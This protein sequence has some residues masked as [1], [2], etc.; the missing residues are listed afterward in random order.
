MFALISRAEKLATLTDFMKP[1]Y[2]AV[3]EVQFYVIEKAQ[4]YVYSLK[5][6]SLKKKFGKAGEGPQEFKIGGDPD[7]L[8]LFPQ[9][10][11]LFF[12]SL[13]KISFFTKGGKFIKE[14]R[15]TS[16]IP[17][18]QPMGSQFVGA[19]M[20]F[21]ED[22][23]LSFAVNLYN[24]NLEKVR[25][26]HRQKMVSRGRLQFPIIRPSFSVSDNKIILRGEGGFLVNIFDKNG[27]IFHKKGI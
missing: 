2:L 7:D 1:T 27:N 6:F 8:I 20:L 3:D 26:I 18:F 11:Y 14:K 16:Q 4:V 19:A 9:P 12:N 17:L 24:E 21:G 15:T 10:D 13:G 22:R 23:S 25:E 5:D